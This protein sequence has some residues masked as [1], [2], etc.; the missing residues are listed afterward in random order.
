[1]KA[2]ST[3][4]LI[5]G[6]S[7]VLAACASSGAGG[8]AENSTVQQWIDVTNQTSEPVTVT[9]RVGA[10]AEQPLGFFGP[11]EYRRVKVETGVATTDE[12]YLEARNNETGN[13]AT[14]N[15]KV[16]PGQT[17]RWDIQF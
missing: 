9:A 8:V 12:I 13:H 15:L 3:T 11:A 1:M 5:V 4:L 6:L 17:L 16:T 2:L 14:T 10:G 7:L